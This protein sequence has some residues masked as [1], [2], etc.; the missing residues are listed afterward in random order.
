MKPLFAF[1]LATAGFASQQAMAD[2]ITLTDLRALEFDLE[3]LPFDDYANSA[4]RVTLLCSADCP[5]ITAVDIQLG[6]A[7]EG[8][9]Q[10]VRDGTTDA[11]DITALCEQTAS[12]T[13]GV[14]CLSVE[15]VTA[16][17]YAGW[18]SDVGIPEEQFITTYQV[19][20]GDYA[21]RLQ[22]L[23]PDRELARENALT[24]FPLLMP[25]LVESDG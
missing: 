2:G 18:L 25:Q 17:D 12:A 21:I 20:G 11:A 6:R 14:E 23:S 15:M 19:F 7:E 24:V 5:G 8:T 4:D 13:P 1:A 10:R 3:T 16:D 22:S 9:E